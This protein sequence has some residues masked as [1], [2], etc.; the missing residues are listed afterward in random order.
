MHKKRRHKVS[1]YKVKERNLSQYLPRDGSTG[2]GIGQ[3]MVVVL[4]V[5]ATASCDEIE[6]V[7]A[8]GPHLSGAREGAIERIIGVVH[9]IAAE[10]GFQA[11]FVEGFVVRHERQPLYAGRNLG[12]YLGEE[13]RVLRVDLRET[14]HLRAEV[15]INFGFGFDER[16][17]LVHLNAISINDNAHATH[18]RALV[19][20]RFEINSCEVF[21][22]VVVVILPFS[23]RPPR[24][25]IRA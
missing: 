5:V 21:H 2:F 24:P 16:I 17:E 1:P 12:P 6:G 8:F 22:T 3:G 20:G 9:L 7:R 14:M 10:H 11:T 4:K 23:V 19:V 15:V 13:W 18:A 25:A